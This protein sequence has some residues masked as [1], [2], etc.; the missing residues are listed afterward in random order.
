MYI[1]QENTNK[2]EIITTVEIGPRGFIE[3]I[4]KR[5]LVP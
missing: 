4:H 1:L 2:K 3:F 5:Y